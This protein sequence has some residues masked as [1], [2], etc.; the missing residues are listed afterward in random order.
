MRVPLTPYAA[1]APPAGGAALDQVIGATA[2]VSIVTA[3]LL[4][5]AIAHRTRRTTLVQRCA[6]RVARSTGQPPW[7]ALPVAMVLFALLTALLGFLWDV[8]LHAG[9]GRDEGPL[10]NPSHYLILVGLFFIFAA[11]MASIALPLNERP[12]PAAVRI[13]RGWYAPVGGILLAGT[14][15]YALIGFPLDDVWHRIFGQ[16]VTLWGP[17][18]LM[19]TGGAGFSLVGVLVLLREGSAANAVAE[20]PGAGP[21]PRRQWVMRC[22]AMGGLLIGLS[23]FQ[24]EYDFGVQQFRQVLQPMMIAGAAALALVA[25][26][27]YIGRG[28]ALAAAVFFLV[29]RGAVALIVGPVL[30]QAEHWFPL[31][32]GCAVVVELLGL[33]A[34]VRRPLL[35]GAAGGI[36]IATLGLAVESWW[37]HVVFALPWTG[38]IGAEALAMAIPVAI[39]TGLCGALL[40]QGL[41]GRLPGRARC[42]SIVVGAILVTGLATANGLYATVPD[43]AEATIV[44][45]RTDSPDGPEVTAQ[46]TLEPATV[47]DDTPS[48]V[49]ITAWQGGGEGVVV[50]RL[51]R[52]GDG[53]YE[54]TRPV[55]V[56][57]NW[58]TLLRVADGRTL[59][60]APIYLAEDP[61][62]DAPEVPAQARSVREL[63]P[64]IDLLQRE[65]DLDVPAWLW[66]VACL[67]V[68]ACSLAMFAGLSW[69]VGR[70]GR[71]IASADSRETAPGPGP[72]SPLKSVG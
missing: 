37:T 54:S 18:H 70:V 5:V 15:L 33:T 20:A 8:S 30:G 25:A 42:G 29:V 64:E 43:D 60:A 23:V 53:T 26:R 49:Q 59:T 72:A 2:A 38:D 66:N 1:E 58:K 27:L 63:G 21:S 3:V 48:W 10:A 36:V 62:I 17:T 41:D 12:G 68:L 6:D 35:F 67:V 11:G 13:T 34:L 4:L 65:R 52:T 57:G 14:G 22:S 24:A 45:D 47:V 39:G 51:E 55:P 71:R 16:D 19:L 56:G 50:D 28:A 46:V 32:L 31:Y 9:R 44:L 40:A 61:A 69:G 7:A